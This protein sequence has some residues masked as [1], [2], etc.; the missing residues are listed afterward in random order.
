MVVL[1]EAWTAL[2]PVAEK[3]ALLVKV[4]VAP[5]PA[6]AWMTML[7]L[8]PAATWPAVLSVEDLTFENVNCWPD[9]PGVTLAPLSVALTKLTLAGSVSTTALAAVP[10]VLAK[11]SVYC[12]AAGTRCG[13]IGQIDRQPGQAGR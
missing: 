7:P 3:L 12:S 2:S 13:Q 8:A 6:V 11:V 4:P 1:A 9:W 5:L 10:P